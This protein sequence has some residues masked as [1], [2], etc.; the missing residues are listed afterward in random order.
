MYIQPVFSSQQRSKVSKSQIDTNFII[1]IYAY[2]TLPVGLYI[3]YRHCTYIYIFTGHYKFQIENLHLIQFFSFFSDLFFYI[4]F[5][6]KRDAGYPWKISFVYHISQIKRKSFYAL[7][8]VQYKNKCHYYTYKTNIVFVYIQYAYT[9]YRVWL[10][11]QY[12]RIYVYT[13]QDAECVCNCVYA[14]CI[15]MFT[16]IFASGEISKNSQNN[17]DIEIRLPKKKTGKTTITGIQF[18]KYKLRKASIRPTRFRNS[19]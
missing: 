3:D 15:D 12:T 6:A 7:L 8:V 1:F 2:S 18:E 19:T 14:C 5:Y 17:I 4:T 16:G 13:A 11:I 10:S 9:T